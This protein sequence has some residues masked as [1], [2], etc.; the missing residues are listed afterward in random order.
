MP[1]DV[2]DW[3]YDHVLPKRQRDGAGG[4]DLMRMCSCQY[5]RCGHCR[6]GRHRDCTT[7]RPGPVRSAREWAVVTD[8][9]AQVVAEVWPARGE[10]CRW[11]C[12]CPADHHVQNTLLDLFASEA[13]A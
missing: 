3:I 1:E 7:A 13:S 8:R 12:P 4:R 11:R 6:A 5:G 9:R 2:A 10:A